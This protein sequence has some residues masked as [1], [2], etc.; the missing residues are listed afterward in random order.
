MQQTKKHCGGDKMNRNNDWPHWANEYKNG[1]EFRAA[2]RAEV[3][4]A[5]AALEKL[6]FG[7][8]YTP[9]EEHI[10]E[11]TRH[12]ESAKSMMAVANWKR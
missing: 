8:A 2:K 10:V 7:C 3:R 4:M 9:V 12:L 1:R 5:L 6:R 11:A